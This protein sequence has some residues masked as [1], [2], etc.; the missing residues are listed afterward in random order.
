MSAT[1]SPTVNT[2]HLNDG[3]NAI[4][5]AWEHL[6][7]IMCGDD[8][9]EPCNLVS[10]SEQAVDRVIAELKSGKPID[11]DDLAQLLGVASWELH[12]TGMHLNEVVE[13]LGLA[14]MAA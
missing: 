10:R 2:T 5:G 11:R 9:N 8:D 1:T 4:A 7:A 3:L 6:D 14:A 12:Q 13:A